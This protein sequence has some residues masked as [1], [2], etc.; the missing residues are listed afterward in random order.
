LYHAL[1]GDN[2]DVILEHYLGETDI[3][4]HIQ[5]EGERERER[6]R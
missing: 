1:L 3:D 4:R 5:R 2:L 6:E